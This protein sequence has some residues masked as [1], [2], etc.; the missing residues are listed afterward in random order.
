MQKEEPRDHFCPLVKE[1]CQGGIIKVED[2]SVECSFR[3]TDLIP[4]GQCELFRV[5]T[6]LE[7]LE[8]SRMTCTL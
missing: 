8:R 2:R 1:M 6:K 4:S 5:L 7:N 3:V